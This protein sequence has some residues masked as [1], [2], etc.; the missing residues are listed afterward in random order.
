MNMLPESAR[1]AEAPPPRHRR[2]LLRALG[3][4]LLLLIAAGAWLLGTQGGL[5]FTLVRARAFTHGALSVRQAQGRL[6]GSL[7]LRGVRWRGANGLEIRIATARIDYAPLALLRKRLDITRLDVSG[8]RVTLPAPQPPS[9]APLD[10]HAPLD[11][12]IAKA[13]LRDAL[14]LRQQQRVFAVNTLSLRDAA[15]THGRLAFGA[16]DLDAPQL[17]LQLQGQLGLDGGW[18]GT[19]AA[20]LRVPHQPQALA[21]TLHARS[22]GRSATLDAR[23]AAPFAATLHAQLAT[24]APYAW[25]GTLRVPHFALAMLLPGNART[26]ALDLQGHGDVMQALLAGTLDVDAWPLRLRALE[27]QRMGD[28]LQLRQLALASPRMPGSLDAQGH[29]ALAAHPVSADLALRWRGVQLPAALLGQALASAG[30]AQFQGNA[31][32]YRVQS[33]FSLDVSGKQRA[34]VTLAVHGDTR[35][36]AVDRLRLQ[37]TRGR[38]EVKGDV[39]LAAPHAWRIAARATHFDPALLAPAWPGD[40][41]FA[42]GSSGLLDARG[43]TGTLVLHDL[44]GT[45]RGRALR[46]S[47]NLGVHGRRLPQGTLDLASGASTLRYAGTGG[48]ATARID[49]RSLADFLP[50]AS[51]SLH[52]SISARGVW[53][54]LDLDAQI[55]ASDVRDATLRLGSAT[56]RTQVRNLAAPHGTAQ[57]SAR[58]LQLG[59][60]KLDRFDARVAGSQHALTLHVDAGGAAG[61]FALDASASGKTARDWQGELRSLQLTPA[62]QVA[63][64]LQAP[65]AWR[66][67]AGAFS[68][69]DACLSQDTARLCVGGS[70][71]ADG[72][73]ALDYRLTALPLASLAA[74]APLPDGARVTGTLDGAGALRFDAALHLRGH[75]RLQSPSGK[76]SLPGVDAQPLGWRD[77]RVQADIGAQS[78][79]FSAHAALLPAGTLDASATLSGAQQALGGRIVLGLPQLHVLEPFVPQLAR[80]A[81]ALAADFALAGT[82]RAPT[83]IG[84]ARVTG[85]AAELPLLGLHFKQ[86]DMTVARA[87]DGALN[88]GGSVQSGAGTLAIAGS[89]NAQDFALTLKGQN[90]LAADLPAARVQVSPDLRF[91]RS[92]T[93]YV[94]DGSVLIPSAQVDLAKLPGA[95]AAQASPDVVIVNAPPLTPVS[96]LPLRASVLVKLGAAVKLR[97]F[98]L[99]GKLSGQLHVDEQPGRAP[100]G[101]GEIGV[102]GTYR[103]YGQDLTLKQSRLLFAGTPLDNPG[104]DLTAERVL[105]DVTPGLRISGTAQRPV[106]QVF[107]TPAME[108]SEALSYLITG[109]P[110]SALKSGQGDMLN[111]AAQ[112]LGSAGGDLLAKE[113]GAR[114][115]VDASVGDNAALGGAALTVG[116]YLSPR[117]YVGYGV[118]LFTPG[119]IVTLRYK[120]SRL[121]DFE[122]QTSALYNRFSLKYR[123]EK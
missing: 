51:G 81:G 40:L 44:H 108:Q 93:G 67:R 18:P 53:P 78:G 26:L 38:L 116:K 87:A 113:I 100:S 42:L 33:D 90:I 105:P 58:A 20:R 34:Q 62:R 79:Q 115:G 8:L 30:S 122:A 43:P 37:Q 103:A 118:G 21:L 46:G 9:N 19:L 2:W 25:R 29:I 68:L 15:W 35:T 48:A 7:H 49:V 12:H 39:A 117:L 60:R 97:G 92:A 89:G 75:A 107:S 95:G 36:L 101:R 28:T 32:V 4:L 57:L 47:A 63:W 104:L 11:I 99:D 77:L 111:S 71:A 70:R 114:I 84:Q 1:T 74:L 6:W 17:A 110:L 76:L 24:R 10:L 72:S 13:T 120:L 94:L 50:Q 45:L 109:K 3:V 5:D 69:A 102:S 61:Q 91:T 106:L 96:P 112:A 119:Q 41:D 27:V 80:V 98:G 64:T 59:A 88:F 16:F 54:T 73:G 23:V 82:L 56:L 85:F 65:A 86:G 55:D 14:I 66:Y 121:F 123:V 22:D 31:Q 52:G 83:L